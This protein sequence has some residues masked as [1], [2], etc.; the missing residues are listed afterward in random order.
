LPGW[1]RM[2]CGGGSVRRSRLARLPAMRQVYERGF[3][4]CQN[5]LRL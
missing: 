1:W 5:R 4:G 3:K 2:R